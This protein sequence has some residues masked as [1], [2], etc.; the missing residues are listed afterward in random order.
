MPSDEAHKP[1][2]KAEF[3]PEGVQNAW[4]N[5][6][7][8]HEV[9]LGENWANKH[10][11]LAK[12]WESYAE[13]LDEYIDKFDIPT[14]K[15][16]NE[17][18]LEFSLRLAQRL[19]QVLHDGTGNKKYCE[20]PEI[21]I[22][23]GEGSF[24]CVLGAQIAARACENAGINAYIG[25]P[26]GH[27]GAI[28]ETEP[29]KYVFVDAAN[30]D[31]LEIEAYEGNAD[32]GEASVGVLTKLLYGKEHNPYELVPIVTK[33]ESTAITIN[34]LSY[35]R[36]I[37]A[38]ESIFAVEVVARLELDKEFPYDRAKQHFLPVVAELERKN[39]WK[40]ERDKVREKLDYRSKNWVEKVDRIS[41]A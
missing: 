35:M 40:E 41:K 7:R 18:N 19:E 28:V 17:T 32:I 1:E 14:Q 20:N 25:L 16:E 6:S 33:A 8:G 27:A 29:N 36:D 30:T 39:V 26:V 15:Q 13:G 10:E 22:E 21:A 31:I 2:I 12:M 3:G 5:M 11:T 23:L 4:N 37:A 34:N 38:N 9:N 24:N